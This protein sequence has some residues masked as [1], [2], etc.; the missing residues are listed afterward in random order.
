MP[1]GRPKNKCYKHL[2]FQLNVINGKYVALCEI[3]EK[4]LTNTAESRLR[5][6][7]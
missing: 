4:K 1:G 3:C 2:H 7:R 5:A 6:H